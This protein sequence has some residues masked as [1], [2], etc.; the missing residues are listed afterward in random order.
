MIIFVA[1]SVSKR[2]K[3]GFY[4]ARAVIVK[5]L[6][7]SSVCCLTE[8]NIWAAGADADA[9]VLYVVDVDSL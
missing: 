5:T 2:V 9:G 1:N 8:P 3:N 4:V 7:E 6:P